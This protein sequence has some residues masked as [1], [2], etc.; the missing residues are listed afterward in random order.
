[1]SSLVLAATHSTSRAHL[2]IPI[3]VIVLGFLN[4]EAAHYGRP[5]RPWSI[6]RV[7]RVEPTWE[8]PAFPSTSRVR[9]G[10]ER[11]NPARRRRTL[12]LRI[13]RTEIP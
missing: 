5:G 2:A 12:L 10:S 7:G 4:L 11:P 9:H 1:M 6:R 3:V 13:A 8:L